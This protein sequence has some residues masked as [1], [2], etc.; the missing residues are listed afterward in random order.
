MN[1]CNMSIQSCHCSADK[2]TVLTF[3]RSTLEYISFWFIL[4]M[5]FAPICPFF[6]NSGMS[7]FIPDCGWSRKCIFIIICL[8]GSIWFID[9]RIGIVDVFL[10]I[11]FI[12]FI[13]NLNWFNAFIDVW[14]YRPAVF[15]I[16]FL[17]A[18]SCNL[19][20]VYMSSFG[21]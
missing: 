10:N 8:I 13:L 14:K 7:S 12:R 5:S 3:N 2:F 18:L 16:F 6:T 9:I 15:C 11:C 17:C 4:F 19:L 20:E 1:C 21:S